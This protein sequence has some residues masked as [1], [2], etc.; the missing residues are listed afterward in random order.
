M[1]RL[2][3]PFIFPLILS[4]FLPKISAIPRDYLFTA[5]DCR[6]PKVISD[7]IRKPPNQDC[8][9]PIRLSG[10]VNATFTVLQR[11]T[12]SRF[13]A[14]LCTVTEDRRVYGCGMFSHSTPLERYSYTMAPVRVTGEQCRRMKEENV[15]TDAKGRQQRM[16]DTY[17]NG[18]YGTIFYNEVGTSDKEDGTCSGGTWYDEEG[19]MHENFRVSINIR[20]RFAHAQMQISNARMYDMTHNKRLPCHLRDGKC[21]GAITGTYY[22]NST[23]IPACPVAYTKQKVEGIIASEGTSDQRVFMSTDGNMIRLILKQTTSICNAIVTTTNYENIFL[24]DPTSS[25]KNPFLR[26][27][28]AADASIH[29]YVQNRDDFL[30]ADIL[31]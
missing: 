3:F 11:E 10:R 8:A 21:E 1:A 6:R 2:F 29:T 15:Y 16:Q 19:E 9:A 30:Y 22:W 25:N 23:S 24:Y 31:G 20:Y 26:A 7:I 14:D 13:T 12:S 4:F 17:Q 27:I 18:K 5:Y 28:A